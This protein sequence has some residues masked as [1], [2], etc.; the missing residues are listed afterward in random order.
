MVEETLDEK[1]Q[2]LSKTLGVK[3]TRPRMSI[4]TKLDLY[5]LWH[6]ATGGPVKTPKPSR[7]NVVASTKWNARKKYEK[8]SKDEA[9][10]KFVEL[11]EKVVPPSNL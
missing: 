8:L 6:Q 9:K 4:Q 2:R 7:V 10:R 1:F 5:G 3:A 11:A